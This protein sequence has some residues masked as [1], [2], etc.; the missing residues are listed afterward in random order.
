MVQQRLEAVCDRDIWCLQTS[1]QSRSLV[2]C[3]AWP[4]RPTCRLLAMLAMIVRRHVPSHLTESRPFTHR[5]PRCAW[6]SRTSASEVNAQVGGYTVHD[7][8]AEGLLGHL[9][10]Q[11]HQQICRPTFSTLSVFQ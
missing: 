7:D 5:M 3:H 2:G 8:Q 9:G 1:P 11:G 10:C 6:S 4:A